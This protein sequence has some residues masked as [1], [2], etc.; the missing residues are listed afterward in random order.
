MKRKMMD[1]EEKEKTIL[2]EGNNIP[3]NIDYIPADDVVS[4]YFRQMAS[5]PLLTHEQEIELARRIETGQEAQDVLDSKPDLTDAEVEDLEKLTLEGQFA[6]DHFARANTRLVVSIAKRYR[7]QGFPMSDLIQEGNIGLMIAIDKFDHT[8]GYHFSTYATW[9]IRQTITQALAKKSRLIRLSLNRSEKLRRSGATQEILRQELGRV[10]TEDE[11]GDR[12]EMEPDEIR[13]LVDG[14]PQTIALETTIGDDSELGD[15]IEDED[16]PSLDE[17]MDV[18]MLIDV[19]ED[20]LGELVPREANILR[21][22]F[23]LDDGNPQTLEQVGDA[24]GLSRERI[25]QIEAS[26]LRKLR[27]PYYRQKLQDFVAA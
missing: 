16:S 22:R 13:D 12:L 21:L 15:L 14:V 17:A 3:E 25:R 20:I 2:F 1:M 8:L 18:I 24:L 6:R 7:N 5:E 19:I 23:G 26:V 11:I 10:P 9:W 27:E 4:L